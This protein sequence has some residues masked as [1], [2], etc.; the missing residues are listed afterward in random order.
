MREKIS[1]YKAFSTV[2]F[3]SQVCWINMLEPGPAY[4]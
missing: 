3:L 2:R 1:S 4:V